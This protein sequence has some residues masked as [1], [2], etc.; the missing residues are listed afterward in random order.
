M[1]AVISQTGKYAIWAVVHLAEAGGSGP[2][3]AGQVARTV[4]SPANYLAKIL[5]TLARA[6]VLGSTRGRHD[7]FR[8]AQPADRITLAEVLAPFEEVQA[9]GCMLTRGSCPH[10]DTCRSWG[11]C[12]TLSH[13]L[14]RFLRN[15]RIA[16]L[17]GEHDA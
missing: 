12:A 14:A 11:S 6:G 3:T 7:G 2:M 16:D 15:T 8:L 13:E 4:G 1:E 17:M 5:H 10:E 9:D